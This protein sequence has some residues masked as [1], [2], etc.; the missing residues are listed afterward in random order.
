[1][2]EERNLFPKNNTTYV[3]AKEL[4]QQSSDMQS[5]TLPTEKVGADLPFPTQKQSENCYVQTA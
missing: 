4:K 2:D 1:M 3:A 5:S